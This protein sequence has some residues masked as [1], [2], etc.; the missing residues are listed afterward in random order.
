MIPFAPAAALLM[1]LAVP[2]AIEA[3]P[4][5][6]QYPEGAGRAFP[7]LRSATGERLAQ[8]EVTQLVRGGRVENRLVFR[9]QDGSL[10]D[11]NVGFSQDG[12]FV[13]HRYRLV[14]RGPSFPESLEATFDRDTE[15]YQVR[16]RSDPD[17][18]VQVL[19]G[20]FAPPLDAYNGM[21]NLIARNLPAGH[22][23]TVQ[24]VAFTPRPRTVQMKLLPLAE[25]PVRLGELSLRATRYAIRPQLGL[26]ASL[27]V[28]DI[29]D[30]HVWVLQG[31]PPAFL[32]FEGPLFFMGPIWRIDPF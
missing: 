21:L 2:V 4:V 24:V 30:I 22:M 3:A 29:P 18:E 23:E 25:E 28:A 20:Q 14:Q 19:E 6:V 12:V 8:G 16:Y 1:I 15:R 31:E 26:L 27:L 10:Y 7:V 5:A 11:E 13:L 9:F 17:R 32:R